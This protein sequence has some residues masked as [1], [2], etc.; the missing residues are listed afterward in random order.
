[1]ISLLQSIFSEFQNI[2]LFSNHT[3]WLTTEGKYLAELLSEKKNLRRLFIPEHGFFAECQDQHKL[4]QPQ[5]DFI[6]NDVDIVSLYGNTEESLKPNHKHFDDIDALIIDIRDAGVRYFTFITHSYYF[7]Q[8]IQNSDRNIKIIVFDYP[9]AAGNQ[10]EGTMLPEKYSSFLGVAGLPHR[11]GLS[12]GELCLYFKAKLN[13]GFDLHIEKPENDFW[14]QPSPNMPTRE[15]VQVY[16]GQCLFE[17][18]TLSE[19]RGTTKP[20]EI[21]GAPFLSCDNVLKIRNEA[22]SEYPYAKDSFILRPLQF[23]PAFHKY[24]GEICNGFQLHVSGAGYHSLMFSMILLRAIQNITGT[25]IFLKEPYEY[26]SN[27]PAIE[28]LLG[29]DF[30]LNFVRGKG[31]ATDIQ[32]YLRVNEELW[33]NKFREIGEDISA[34]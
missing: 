26:G 3:S 6:N 15:T 17:G 14:I 29:D 21:F 31:N 5:Y 8:A 19:G 12:I 7:L 23:V 24:R 16:S 18:T 1:M 25:D 20:F 30:L 13:A 9:N 2:A 4:D 28:I 34:L 10:V 32:K 27:L 11:Y 22:V 33:I